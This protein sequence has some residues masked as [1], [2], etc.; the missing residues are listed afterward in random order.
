MEYA[1]GT[2]DPYKLLAIRIIS[3]AASNYLYWGFGRNGT[4]IEKFW[5]ANEYFFR[6]RSNDPESWK[7]ARYMRKMVIDPVTGKKRF[8]NE[9]LSDETLKLGCFDRHYELSGLDNLMTLDKFTRWL[10]IRREELVRENEDQINEYVELLKGVS[11]EQCIRQQVKQHGIS[12]PAF[13]F[14]TTTP[15]EKMEVLVRPTS[16]VDVANLVYYNKN[17]GVPWKARDL[18]KGAHS[19]RVQSRQR[20]RRRI[21]T[22]AGQLSF[23]PNQQVSEQVA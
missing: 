1:S 5:E 11:W 9:E 18:R 7:D 16:P 6:V 14:E 20:G 13:L 2:D 19:S 8:V 4:T 21:K 17:R 22:Q 10:A 23:L 12:A 15:A 3:D